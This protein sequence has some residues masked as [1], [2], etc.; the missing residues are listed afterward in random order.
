MGMPQDVGVIDLMLGIPE[1]GQ[2]DLWYSFL[3]P[4]LRDHESQ[5]MAMPAQYMFKDI[6]EDPSADDMIGWTIDQMDGH[7]EMRFTFTVRKFADERTTQSVGEAA[8]NEISRQLLQNEP[9]S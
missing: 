4:N 6:P 5:R 2:R 7:G 1:P 8:I 3:A 9:T